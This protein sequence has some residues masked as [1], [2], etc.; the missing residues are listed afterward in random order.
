MLPNNGWPVPRGAQCDEVVVQNL[1]GEGNH[2]KYRRCLYVLSLVSLIYIWPTL[3]QDRRETL[4]VVTEVGPNSMDIHGVGANRPSYGLS[5]NVYDRLL[6]YGK[7]ALPD[8]TATYDYSVLEPELATRWQIAPD[9][10]SVTFTLRPEAKFH[11][12]TPVTAHDVKWSF[13]RA[14]SIGG[15]PTFQMKAGSLEK[16]EQFIVVDDH[17]FRINFLRQDKLTMP[18]LAVPVP[19]IM[20]AKLAQQHAT[21]NDPWAAEWLKS[22]T[23]AGGA[24]KIQSWKPGQETIYSRFDDWKVGSF[25]DPQTRHRTRGTVRV[26]SAGA[27][28]ARRRRHFI[29]S[30]AEGFSGAVE[31]REAARHRRPCRERHV[32]CGHERDQTTL[33][34]CQGTPGR[35]LCFAV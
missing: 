28:R 26:E 6:T 12:G 14:V 4:L 22:N 25:A 24:F 7:K 21:P 2:V 35:G 23:A 17:T 11:D 9:G 3:A 31:S 10:M 5:W 13:D 34:P 30:A 29:R 1:S 19:V 27:A 33:R 15:F 20:N 18:D 16:P 8:G 32:V